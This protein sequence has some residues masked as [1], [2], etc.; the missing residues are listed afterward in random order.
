MRFR[1]HRGGYSESMNTTVEVSSMQQLIDLV[2]VGW[3]EQG[4]V[5]FDYCCLDRRNGWD[6]YYVKV[7]QTIVGM[8]DG[9]FSLA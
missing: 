6:T 7:N 2:N 8:T 4:E 3:F 5:T 9:V 1:W